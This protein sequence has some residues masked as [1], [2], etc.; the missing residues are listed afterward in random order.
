MKLNYNIEKRKEIIISD[1]AIL[2][3]EFEMKMR[4]KRKG[5]LGPTNVRRVMNM[6]ISQVLTHRPIKS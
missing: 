2:D 5:K 4:R 1:R 3:A 6:W